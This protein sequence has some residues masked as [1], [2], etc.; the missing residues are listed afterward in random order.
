MLFSCGTESACVAWWKGSYG[1][2]TMPPGV[3]S[4][5]ENS[6]LTFIEQGHTGSMIT[7]GERRFSYQREH[8]LFNKNK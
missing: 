8:T 2:A 5:P 3:I 4:P 6:K 7:Q 1:V